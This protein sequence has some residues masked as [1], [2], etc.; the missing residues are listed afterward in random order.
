MSWALLVRFLHII[1]AIVFIGGIFARQLVRAHAKQAGDVRA[2]ATLS[3]AAGWIETRMVI[4]GNLAVIVFGVILALIT[5]APILGFL[6]GASRN[7]LLVC[8]ILLLF[9]F[10]AVP[11]VFVPRGKKFEPIL[12]KALAE[13]QM[14]L[15]LRAALNDRVV[16]FFHMVE[17]IVVAFIILLMVFRPF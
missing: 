17:L 3:Q 11:F 16:R 14:T 15:E 13:G 8:N 1:S 5:D 7:W 6:Q 4:P 2:F 9:G 10:F 12:Q